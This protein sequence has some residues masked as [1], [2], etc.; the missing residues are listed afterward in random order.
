VATYEDASTDALS[1]VRDRIDYGL[2]VEVARGVLIPKSGGISVLTAPPVFEQTRWPM[3]S[4]HLLSEGPQ[5][6]GVGEIVETD[7]YDGDDWTE[8]EGWLA[9]AQI[10]VIGWSLNPD[11]RIALRQ[12][13][14]RVVIANLPVFDACGM[15]QI[16]F[17]QQDIDAVSGEYPAP[18][19]QAAGTLTCLAPIVVH[20]RAD[21]ITD[22][23]LTVSVS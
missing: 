18:V 3:V 11:E 5:Q 13:L 9:R 16:E 6:R 15:L 17:M 4:V 23:Q 22:V 1:V 10:A 7:F 2:A 8:S 19:Y 14:R 12:A 20:G 21:P